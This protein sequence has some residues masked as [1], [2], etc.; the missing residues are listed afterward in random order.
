MAC[1]KRNHTQHPAVLAYSAQDRSHVKITVSSRVSKSPPHSRAWS[2]AIRW[3]VVA[4]AMLFG[5][6][7][8]QSIH[9]SKP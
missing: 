8:T 5:V 1:A 7:S 6:Y 4:H 3:D 2:A 9:L